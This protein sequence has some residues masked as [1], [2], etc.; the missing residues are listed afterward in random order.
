MTDILGIAASQKGIGEVGGTSKYG[1]WLDAQ[2]GTHLYYNLDWCGAFQMW[3]IAQGGP[4]WSAAAGGVQRGFAEVQVWLDWMIA[5][6]RTS[7]TPHARRLVWYDWAG[8]PRGANH[9][10][11]VDHFTSS[12]IWAWEGNHNNRVELVER[13]RDGQ[14]MAY[15][16]WWSFVPAPAPAADDTAIVVSLGA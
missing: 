6:E 10:G 7:R 11:L 4:E 15:A 1:K 16:E 8:T 12:H 5:H 9:I 13:P 2:A 3:A 14:I